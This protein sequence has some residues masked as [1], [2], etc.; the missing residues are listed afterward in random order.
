VNFSACN[1]LLTTSKV[2]LF[3]K[4][5]DEIASDGG[6]QKKIETRTKEDDETNQC[7]SWTERSDGRISNI[8][9]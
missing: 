4:I 2:E 8:L 7:L 9:L 5:N 6:N 1:R 3:G